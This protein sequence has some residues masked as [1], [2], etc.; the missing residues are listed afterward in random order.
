MHLWTFSTFRIRETEKRFLREHFVSR[1]L[2]SV[3][4]YLGGPSRVPSS[5]RTRKSAGSF[6][7]PYSI[8]LRTGFAWHSSFPEP[9]ELLPHLF[10]LTYFTGG[11]FLWHFPLTRVNWGLPSILP[12]GARTF[13]T[14]KCGH[15]QYS[16]RCIILSCF[17]V[18]CLE[19]F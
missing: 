19:R 17:C 15:K 18:S 12:F 8:L 13:L 6:I 7:L 11:I 1:V 3:T 14:R 2:S 4:I 10:T 5:D 16:L 9:G